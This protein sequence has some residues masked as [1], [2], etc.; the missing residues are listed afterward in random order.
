M[1]I[2]VKY[3]HFI[4]L[5]Y[6]LMIGFEYQ[7][8]MSLKVNQV[9]E[10]L[11]ILEGKLERSE[12]DL[13]KVKKFQENLEESK[14]RV[15]EVVAEIEK[16]QRQLP[17]DIQDTVVTG[18]LSDFANDLKMLNPS[19]AP[20]LEV[21]NKFYISKEYSFSAQATFLQVLIFFEKL[22]NLS[23]SDRILN[24]K[25]LKMINAKNA[26]PRSRFKILDFDTTV[27]A[28]RY[29]NAYDPTQDI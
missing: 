6:C 5:A 21:D 1:N 23:K 14:K 11:L 26:D 20:K 18:K 16:M 28:Y 2:V 4:I 7:E 27:E 15:N 3:L 9:S 17:S 29:N 24:V 22:E 13:S 19:S 25:R 8:E 10:E 12:R